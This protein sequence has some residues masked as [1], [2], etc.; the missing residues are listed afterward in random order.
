[1]QP[2]EDAGPPDAVSIPAPS[3]QPM[4]HWC[5]ID[6]SGRP[7]LLGRGPRYWPQQRISAS[8]TG[9]IRLAGC[10]ALIAFMAAI[11]GSILVVQHHQD[12]W[13][14][15]GKALLTL[16]VSLFIGGGVA[17]IVKV[18]DRVREDRSTW[19]R[20]LQSIVEVDQALA[21]A[22]QLILA[23]R[24][25]KTYS[26]QHARIVEAR[27][28]LR[29]VWDDP[30]VANDRNSEQ[31]RDHLDRMKQ[32]VDGLGAEYQNDYLAI[33]RQQRVDEE[34]LKDQVG[35]LAKHYPG[36]AWPE[37]PAYR[38]TR[39]WELL[40]SDGDG[41]DNLRQLIGD[42]YAETGFVHAFLS[43]RPMLEE[44]AGIRQQKGPLL[45]PTP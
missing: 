38:P 21:V 19:G 37:D 35:R 3:T 7:R 14:D 2:T 6:R 30:L 4:E 1:M 26:D 28:V 12:G 10:L 44:R 27:L 42:R 16:S 24:T 36:S 40:R 33:A 20:L 18:L 15:I 34:Y 9:M 31:L 32:F 39:A 8:I 43:L 5:H 25:A 29:R 17:A 22:R 11:P 45:P 23:H 13:A 41:F